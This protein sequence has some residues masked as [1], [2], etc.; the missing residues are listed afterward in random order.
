MK[1]DILVVI[2][3]FKPQMT[4]NEEISL[5]QCC[6][7]FSNYTFTLVVPDDLDVGEYVVE[8]RSFEINYKVQRFHNN[9]F[10]N[11]SGYNRLLLSVEFYQRFQSY[12]YILIYQLDAYVFSDELIY[13]CKKD[14]D[15]I[16]APLIGKF[17]DTE[18]STKMRVGNGGFS[19]RKVETYIHFF[20]SKKKVFTHKQIASLIN[21]WKKPYT[22]IFVWLLMIL[23]WRNK[24]LSCAKYWKYNEDDF[25][26]GFLDNSN[27]ALRKPT[28]PEA[29][30]FAF[31]RFPKECFQQTGTL[32]FGCHAWEK[33]NYNS[34][35]KK[36]II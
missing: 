12:K 9:Y 14:Y 17:E 10:K 28:P 2:P 1:E 23:G 24:P 29:L 16:G 35:W 32:P 31:E 34:F 33:Y 4:L 36:Y 18:F 30:R 5:R 3:V 6:Q 15:F 19:L 13:W 22:R 20:E 7:V 27:Y 25:W 21:I 11:I 8:F 26:S